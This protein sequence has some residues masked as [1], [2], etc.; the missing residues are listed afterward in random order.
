M[1]ERLIEIVNTSLEKA[2]N[3]ISK[4]NDEILALDG[5]TGK[6]T[7]HFYN[8]LL[9]FPDISYLEVGTY[10]GS[11]T[12]AAMYGNEAKVI[13][14]DNWSEFG[15]IQNKSIFLN[16]F[17]KFKG[18]NTAMFIEKDCFKIEPHELPFTSNIY[19]YDGPHQEN[20]H[21]RALK[22]FLP[23]LE[24]E[25][26]YIVDDWNWEQVRKG[27]KKSIQ[28][29]NLKVLYEKEIRLTQDNSVTKRPALTETWWNGI[30]IA[31]LQK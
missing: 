6:K 18:N 7:R 10:K 30:Y 13:A 9:S 17:K 27:T 11:S 22:Q 4:V 26:I 24:N 25:F 1:S 19:M 15:G 20:D 23:C 8:N 12:C 16:N 3:N 5:M 21:Y 29:L 2:E 28:D 14:I 31:V